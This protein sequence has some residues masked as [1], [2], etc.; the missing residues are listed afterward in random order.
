[1][2]VSRGQ[3]LRSLLVFLL[4]GCDPGAGILVRQ[5][6]HPAPATNCIAAAIAASPKVVKVS[7]TEHWRDSTDR[8]THFF[9][10][11]RDS[12]ER[13][14]ALGVTVTNFETGYSGPAL[15]VSVGWLGTLRTY[16]DAEKERMLRLSAAL[17]AE[18]RTVCAPRAPEAVECEEHEMRRSNS[19]A[20]PP[21]F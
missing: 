8:W 9:V 6:I 1:M 3:V 2:T 17:L 5:R 18:L 11:I 16:S 19:R 14:G 20:C 15:T 10:V 7:D 21:P 12:L 13:H 4:A